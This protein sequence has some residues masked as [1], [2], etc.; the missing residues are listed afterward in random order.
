MKK[1]ISLFKLIN[2]REDNLALRH[3]LVNIKNYNIGTR[4]IYT[5]RKIAENRHTPL[6]EIV[7]NV[8]T[9]GELGRWGTSFYNFSKMINDLDSE[10]HSL[11]LPECVIKISEKL[12]IEVDSN[13]QSL[14][15]FTKKMPEDSK[16]SDFL[17]EFNNKTGVDF[18]SSDLEEEDDTIKI[19]TMHASKGL[20]FNKVFVIGFEETFFPN[21]EQDLDE[22][23][24]MCYVSMTRA[25]EELYLCYSNNIV[26]PSAQGFKVYRPSPF[27][28]EIPVVC[29]DII[30]NDN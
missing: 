14:I 12:S 3:C 27:M 4:G 19:L 20:G 9:I 21:S 2:D 1:V 6:W 23:R 15:D 16:I 22:Q 17:K 18:G 11:A 13:I 26:G 8:N 29:R 10:L 25:K 30:T 7:K 5:L 28:T 24:R